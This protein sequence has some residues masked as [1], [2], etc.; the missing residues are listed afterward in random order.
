MPAIK[1]IEQT[2]LALPLEQ[3]VQ[4]AESLLESLPLGGNEW[5][6]AEELAEIE[7]R[8]RQIESGET[9]PISESEFWQKVE[10][11]RKR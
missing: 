9:L 2:I 6:E 5:S 1:E 3:R 7:R 11:R 4:L 8:E 10:A